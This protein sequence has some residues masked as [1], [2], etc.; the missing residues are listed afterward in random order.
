MCIIYLIKPA[1]V[2]CFVCVP[3]DR[4]NYAETLFFEF[5]VSAFFVLRWLVYDTLLN[6]FIILFWMRFAHG[7]WRQGCTEREEEDKKLS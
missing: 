3:F 2:P 6:N 5:L 4:E 1:I 7:C